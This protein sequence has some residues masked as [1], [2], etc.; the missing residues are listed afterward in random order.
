VV[1]SCLQ[2]GYFQLERVKQKDEDDGR[3]E[4]GGQSRQD[5]VNLIVRWAKQKKVS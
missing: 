4:P 3:S 5:G 1:Y 2:S